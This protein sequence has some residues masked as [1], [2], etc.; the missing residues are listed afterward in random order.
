[1]HKLEK[2]GLIKGT[3]KQEGPKRKRKDYSIT[4]NGIYRATQAIKIANDISAVIVA[5]DCSM[6]LITMLNGL[7]LFMISAIV[8]L[9]LTWRYS[10]F[11]VSK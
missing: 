4:A 7:F 8:W 1:L 6:S 5:H 11:V 3:W 2:D 10:K 9:F